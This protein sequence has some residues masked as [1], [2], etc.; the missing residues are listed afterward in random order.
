MP[1][2]NITWQRPYLYAHRDTIEGAPNQSIGSFSHYN[3]PLAHPLGSNFKEFIF[4]LTYQP[5]PRLIF[6]G[7]FISARFGDDGESENW[8]GNIL[9]PLG[10]R[11][12][13]YGNAISQGVRTD[14]KLFGLDVSYEIM[15]NYYL[16]FHVLLRNQQSELDEKDYNTKY[17]G[18]GIRIN[19]T[20]QQL[21]Y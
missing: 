16:D 15:H 6:D 20:S 10:T 9:L 7:R 21:D 5:L 14:I 2:L 4:R 11:E 13:D 17:F 18:V 19:M 8:G 3:Q 12:M 1:R